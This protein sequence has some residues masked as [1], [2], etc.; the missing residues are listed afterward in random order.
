MKRKKVLSVLLAAAMV[1][2]LT[3]CGS[4]DDTQQVPAQTPEAG[5]SAEETPSAPAAGKSDAVTIDFW[6]NNRHDSEYMTAKIEEFNASHDD[7]QIAYNVLTDDW[8]NSVQLAYQA[9]TAPDII[10]VQASDDLKLQTW[11]DAGMLTSLTEYIN[12]DEEFKKVTEIDSNKYEGLNSIG[13]DVYWAPTGVRSGTRI[14]YNTELVKA[15]GADSIPSTLKET[16]ELAKKVTENGNGTTYGVGFT[17]SSPFSRWLEGVGEMSGATHMGYDYKEGKFDFSSWKEVVETA[18]GFFKDASVLPGTETQGVD[19]SR[20][21]FAQG[22]FA[23]W[24]NASQEAGVFTEQFPCNFEWGVAELP[25]L[26]GEVKGALSCSPNGGYAMLSSSENKE[27]AWEVIRYFSSED[28]LKGYLEGGYTIALSDHM[29]GVIDASKTGR[30]AD[31]ALQDY[32]N[33]YPTPPTVTVEGENW[34]NVL[35]NV[36][37]GYVSADDAIADLNTRY[38]DALE[39]GLANGSCKRLV[40]SDFDPLN[41]SAGT[42]DYLTE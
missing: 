25:T 26:S 13:D 23:I 21:L 12:A 18:Q 42:C 2:S 37:L 22:S 32:E 17:S 31:F 40:I 10:S 15:A 29:K 24:G 11:V 30:L 33:V 35:W 5:Q 9:N 27:A 20:A 8:L 6:T 28:F 3:A 39:R 19:N 7:I 4:G 1:F 16:V 38:N 41:P 36:V 34:Q 14:E